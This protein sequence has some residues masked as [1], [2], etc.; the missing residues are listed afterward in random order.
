MP[1]L[2][3]NISQSQPAIA[4]LSLGR[5][6]SHSLRPKLQA[7]AKYGFKGIELFYE[8]LEVFAFSFDPPSQAKVETPSDRALHL[9][10]RT[11]RKWCTDLDLAI[12]N[13]QPLFLDEG[14]TSRDEHLARLEK[15]SLWCKLA[16]TLGTDMVSIPSSVL[17]EER[18]T[19][20][21]NSLVADLHDAACIAASQEP[22]IK[23]S[24][25]A[26][27]WGTRVNTW[28]K[29]WEIIQLADSPNLGICL[30]TFNMC[31]AIYADPTSPNGIINP[32]SATMKT[33]HASAAQLVKTI[34]QD[35]IFLVQLIDAE[36]LT[37]PLLP[38]HEFYDPE[39]PA[40]M[41]WSRN[42]RLFYGESNRGAYLPVDMFVRAIFDT[43][44]GIGWNGWVSM[45]V[46]H[47]EL[48]NKGENVPMNLAKR[49]IKSWEQL[50]DFLN[51][52][53]GQGKEV[54]N[55]IT[56][57]KVDGQPVEIARL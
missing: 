4:T 30:D 45:E 9:A 49:G 21:L 1:A 46:F 11:I 57:K 26:L 39:Q 19:T 10:A 8:D 17:P 24:Y 40:R 7:A 52:M 5:A 2:S 13:L 29:C 15:L 48:F 25:E 34:P 47:R 28:E 20:D 3:T 37:S 23:L 51:Q 56:I 36:R 12:I 16:H 14:I 22:P 41:S 50:Q 6:S 43:S 27:A 38:G 42:C 31:G 35:K 53:P 18:L 55:I 54:G 33:V 44:T 32:V